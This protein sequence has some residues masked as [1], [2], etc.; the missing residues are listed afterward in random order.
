M[1]RPVSALTLRCHTF[2]SGFRSPPISFQNDGYLTLIA[3]V[4]SSYPSRAA[5]LE[6]TMPLGPDE[7][8]VPTH[9]NPTSPPDRL[10]V[11]NASSPGLTGPHSREPST[12]I[13]R[14]RPADPSTLGVPTLPPQSSRRAQ[15]HSK[16]PESTA[17]RPA[18]AAAHEGPIERKP[19]VSYGHHRKTSIVHGIQHS[20]DPSFA[21]SVTTASPLS[22]EII[23]S[24]GLNSTN[25]GAPGP[26][27]PS[28]GRPDQYELHPPYTS[29]GSNATGHVQPS[30]LSTIEDDDSGETTKANGQ[31]RNPTHRKMLSNGKSR[32]DHSRSHS[33]HH[34]QESKTVGE[35][36]LHHLFNSVRVL[37]LRVIHFFLADVVGVSSL[38]AKRITKSIRA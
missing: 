30:G 20:R 34:H 21:T 35:Y 12:S 1:S 32:R 27:V 29:A 28:S 8:P 25:N 13:P 23:A 9:Q 24:V 26:D 14:G 2:A 37:V 18:G 22:P 4:A 15:S 5:A 31:P 10:A 7:S 17:A 6:P 38:S 19:S 36:A 33:K 3:C 16:S 11:R